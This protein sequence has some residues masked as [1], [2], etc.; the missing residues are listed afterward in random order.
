MLRGLGWDV[1][2]CDPPR[3]TREAGGFV[4]LDEVI[5]EC[6]VISLHTPLSM[7]GA[8]PTFH[9]FDRQ[10]LNGLRPNAG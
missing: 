5:A 9:L 7:S 6:D 4:T 8:C 1:R 2:V 3:Q 10:R